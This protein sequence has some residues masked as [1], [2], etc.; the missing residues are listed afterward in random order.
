[1]TDRPSCS[2]GPSS[3]GTSS[4]E[5]GAACRPART[6]LR[7]SLLRVPEPL[8]W[9]WGPSWSSLGALRLL[10]CAGDEALAQATLTP[11]I[12]TL[13]HHPD[14]AAT[15]RLFLD[16]AGSVQTTAAALGIH[17]QT[18]YHRLHRIEALTGLTLSPHL[19]PP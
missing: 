1:M 19:N 14:L 8:P 5:G 2:P 9:A 6:E 15:A 10:R 12:E 3:I 17:R 18:L 16:H 13:L 4:L 7:R 11:G